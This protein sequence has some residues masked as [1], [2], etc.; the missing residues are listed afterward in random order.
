MCDEWDCSDESD[1]NGHS[2]GVNCLRGGDPWYVPV[3]WICDGYADCD[4][5]E[6]ELECEVTNTTLYTCTSYKRGHQVPI[7]NYTRCAV[8]PGDN[9]YFQFFSYCRDYSDQTNCSD[10]ERIGGYCLINGYTSSVSIYDINDI[11]TVYNR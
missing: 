10:V 2:Y 9:G 8:F 11:H 5:G 1:C 3:S 6:D 7:L 4:N